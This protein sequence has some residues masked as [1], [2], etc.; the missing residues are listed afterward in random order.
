MKTT[1]LRQLRTHEFPLLLAICSEDIT[2]YLLKA[3]CLPQGGAWGWEVEGGG[4]QGKCY[5]GGKEG[6][7]GQESNIF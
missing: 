6:A 3:V 4:T 7:K 1:V 5:S 2:G